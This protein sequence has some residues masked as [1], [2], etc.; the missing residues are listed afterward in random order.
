MWPRKPSEGARQSFK[1]C[2]G[3]VQVYRFPRA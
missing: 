2:E 3:K 1:A